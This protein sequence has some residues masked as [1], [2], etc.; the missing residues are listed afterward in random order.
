MAVIFLL[1]NKANY[2]ENGLKTQTHWSFLRV[3][4]CCEL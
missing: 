3:E 2:S 1:R 4:M